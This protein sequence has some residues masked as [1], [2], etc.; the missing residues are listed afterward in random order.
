M[1]PLGTHGGLFCVGAGYSA[2]VAWAVWGVV[3]SLFFKQAS[4]DRGGAPG[5]GTAIGVVIR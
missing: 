5:R 4:P 2:S 3:P 1:T